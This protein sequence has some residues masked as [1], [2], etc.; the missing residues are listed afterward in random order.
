MRELPA[1][2]HGTA[3]QEEAG[4]ALAKETLREGELP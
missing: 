3:S 2:E 1:D 4:W